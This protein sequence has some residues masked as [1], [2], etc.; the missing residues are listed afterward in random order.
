MVD[1]VDLM[2]SRSFV[3]NEDYW[4]SDV[5]AMQ[6]GNSGIRLQCLKDDKGIYRFLGKKK[7]Y[8]V[9]NNI[10]P[11]LIKSLIQC[12]M[13][14]NTLIEGN[15]IFGDNTKIFKFLKIEQLDQKFYDDACFVVSD[16]IYLNDK[17]VFDLPLFDRLA[18][19]SK[20]VKESQLLK[21]QQSFSK[22][23]KQIYDKLKDDYDVF[24]FKH[25]ESTYKFGVRSS[26]WLALKKPQQYF[27]VI[28]GF[29]E[30]E[31]SKYKGLVMALE[32]GQVRDGQVIKIMNVPVHNNDT[33]FLIYKSKDKFLGKVFEIL[34]V[35]RTKDDKFLE[36]RYVGIREDKTIED[37]V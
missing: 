35:D 9:R 13:L 21:V 10:F 1:F 24:N 28:L 30:S 6:P 27:M 15:L 25:L 33:R 16:I 8:K 23:K 29:V 20:I 26:K 3:D 36:A 22:S 18:K 19:L 14:E 34:A 4:Y 32:G 5:W 17:P 11:D 7:N 12:D 31:D 37:C 2:D